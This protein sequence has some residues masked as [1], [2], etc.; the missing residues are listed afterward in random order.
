MVEEAPH[1]LVLITGAAGDI[2]SGL[3]AAL[4]RKYTVVGL[5]QPGKQAAVPLIPI[6]LRSDVSVAGAFAAIRERYGSRI[7]SVIH[8][9]AYFDFTGEENPLY[10]QVNVAG[11]RRLLQALQ[12]F[13]VEQL[14][15]S[16]TM[17]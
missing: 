3:A 6:D 7:A 2:G 8:L 1:P 10:E 15:Y 17:L 12:A 4:A 11:T 13:D 14:I 16:G 5:D 9:A